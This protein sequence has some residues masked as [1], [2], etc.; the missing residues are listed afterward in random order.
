MANDCRKLVS[1][2]AGLT[3]FIGEGVVQYVMPTVNPGQWKAV[4][5]MLQGKYGKPVQER[6][7]TLTNPMSGAKIQV[8]NA[9]WNAP[10]LAG[11]SRPRPL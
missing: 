5:Q 3:L 11:P 10:G 6:W 4:Y 9:A 7:E 2:T 8:P 1:N